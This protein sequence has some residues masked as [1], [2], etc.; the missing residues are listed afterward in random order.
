MITWL[1]YYNSRVLTHSFIHCSRFLV[2]I[3]LP[4]ITQTF[5]RCYYKKIITKYTVILSYTNPFLIEIK[6]KLLNMN[7][8]NV[9]KDMKPDSICI[10]CF[11]NYYSPIRR[12]IKTASAKLRL[13]WADRH[14]LES[15]VSRCW[16][17]WN[18]AG[19]WRICW[20]WKG[21]DL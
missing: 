14:A 21:P 9:W 8:K 7:E 10:K 17:F 18:T 19:V 6:I 15:Y 1:K 2:S 3:F 20:Y 5:R 4:F 12:W 13:R 11:E 16:C